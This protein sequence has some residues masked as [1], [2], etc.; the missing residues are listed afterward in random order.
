MKKDDARNENEERM[1]QRKKGRSEMKDGVHRDL[2]ACHARSGWEGGGQVKVMEGGRSGQGRGEDGEA[3]D[4]EIRARR[5][6]SGCPF[7]RLILPMTSKIW[8]WKA[9]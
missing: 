4:G 9:T 1:A 2:A 5:T 8:L 7:V 3:I 6:E